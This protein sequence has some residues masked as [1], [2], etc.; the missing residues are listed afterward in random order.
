[1]AQSARRAPEHLGNQGCAS[2]IFGTDLQ[3]A[4]V[5]DFGQEPP[6]Q[7]PQVSG[8]AIHPRCGDVDDALTANAN[9]EDGRFCALQHRVYKVTQCGRCARRR[10]AK[11]FDQVSVKSNQCS[12]DRGGSEVDTKRNRNVWMSATPIFAHN[13]CA[14]YALCAI[15]VSVMLGWK[16]RVGP[17][18]IGSS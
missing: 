1:M 3:I 18:R 17:D 14:L 16:M 2:V 11:T 7:K 15:L 10:L 8:Q 9:A 6:F 4:G 12:L 5:D 13:A